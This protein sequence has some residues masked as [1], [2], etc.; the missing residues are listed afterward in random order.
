M[1]L[2]QP[3]KWKL[4]IYANYGAEFEIS[5]FLKADLLAKRTIRFDK[6][7]KIPF[8]N[9]PIVGAGFSLPTPVYKVAKIFIPGLK[10]TLFLGLRAEIPFKVEYVVEL[11]FDLTAF[12]NATFNTGL[13]KI[14]LSITGP[15][16]NLK[17]DLK[18]EKNEANQ[19]S[20]VFFDYDYNV[21]L[22]IKLCLKLFLGV[23]PQL[24]VDLICK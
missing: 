14:N 7:K 12:F 5:A 11:E 4:E 19:V 8:L 1:S 21:D 6:E 13:K 24:I 18:F 17:S 2:R 3:F 16:K 22:A 15:I 10:R 23:E 9:F 20:D